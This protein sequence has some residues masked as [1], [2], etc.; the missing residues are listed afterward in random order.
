MTTVLLHGLGESP[1]SWAPVLQVLSPEGDYRCPSLLDFL[2]GQKATYQNLYSAFCA[3]CD[4]LPKKFHL[5]GLSLGGVLALHYATQ[6]PDRLESLVLIAAQYKMPKGLLTLQNLMFRFMP[7]R[8][9]EG[10]GFTKQDFISLCGSTKE[11]DFT[12]SLGRI[13]CPTLVLC[14]EKDNAN[15][16]AA[17]QLAQRIPGSKLVFIPKAG[18][19]VNRDRPE[20]LGNMILAFQLP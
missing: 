11:L 4:N 16:K 15:K 6:H 1:E 19:Q 14:G 17:S 5:C 12:Q 8:S 13:S 2:A 7:Q 10:I 18:H 20:E 9:F 3:Y